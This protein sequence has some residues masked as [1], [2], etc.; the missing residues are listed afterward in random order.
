MAFASSV[1]LG[2]SLGVGPVAGNSIFVAGAPAKTDTNKVV[3]ID[4][5]TGKPVLKIPLLHVPVSSGLSLDLTVFNYQRPQFLWAASKYN[6]NYMYDGKLGLDD[7]IYPGVTVQKCHS[8]NLFFVGPEGDGH[9]FYPSTDNQNIF[10]SNDGWK[11][12]LSKTGSFAACG[13][14]M[15]AGTI[16]SPNGIVYTISS[17]VGGFSPVTEVRPIA[18]EGN[19]WVRYQYD[20]ENLNSITTSSGYSVNFQYVSIATYSNEMAR[21]QFVS[22]INTSDGKSWHFDYT[23][24]LDTD[25]P[26]SFTVGFALLTQITLP[27]GT[28]WHFHNTGVLLRSSNLAHTGVFEGITYPNGASQNF[29]YS[30]TD[31]FN[32]GPYVVTTE[33]DTNLPI[34]ADITYGY[35]GDSTPTLT[36]VTTPSVKTVYTVINDHPNND[37]AWDAGLLSEIQIYEPQ[38]QKLYKD[39]KFSWQPRQ[40]SNETGGS[41]PELTQQVIN[42]DG[43]TYTL[44]NTQ[45]DPSGYVTHTNEFSSAGLIQ[46]T[47]TYYEDP[48]SWIFKPQTIKTLDADGNTEDEINNTYNRLGELTSMTHNGEVTTYSYDNQ[49]N[50]ATKT[51]ALGHITTYGDYFAGQPQSVTDA[52]GNVSHVVMSNNGTMTSKTDALGHTTRYQYDLMGRLVVETPPIGTP[53]TIKWNQPEL[54][55]E[56]ITKG[57]YTKTIHNNGFN[58]PIET[59]EQDVS[60]QRNRIIYDAYDV[61]GNLNFQS[62]FYDQV[63]LTKMGKIFS[64]DPLGRLISTSYNFTTVN[65]YT[66]S[67]VY[68]PGNSVSLTEPLGNKT[69]YVYRAYSDPDNKQLMS[70]QEGNNVTTT[71]QR[72]GVGQVT[73]IQK[74]NFTRHYAYNANHYLV[75]ET[76]PET[77]TTVYGR[78]ILGNV[79]SEKIGEGGVITYAY[80]DNN[81]LT[82]VTYPEAQGTLTKTYDAEGRVSAVENG[83]ATWS[84]GYDANDNQTSAKAHVGGNDYAFAYAYDGLNHLSSMS[85]P[86]QETLNYQPDAFGEPT[87]ILPM[88]VLSSAFKVAKIQYYPNGN[89]RGYT[90]P[91][92]TVSYGQNEI[93]I[94]NNISINP[95]NLQ[96][97]YEYDAENNLTQLTKVQGGTTAS[98]RFTYNSIKE[99]TSAS[100]TLL[101]G[102]TMSYDDIGNLTQKTEGS[103]Q[104]AYQYDAQNRLAA[105]SGTNPQS[106][107][108]DAQGNMINFNGYTLTYN[109]ANQ[110]VSV[111][112]RDRTDS[113]AYDG[114]GNRLVLTQDGKTTYNF[115]QG[116]ILLYSSDPN[117]PS[118]NSVYFY[119]RNQ[120]VGKVDNDDTGQKVTQ[121]YTDLLG[122]PIFLIS[123]SEGQWNQDYLPY[124]KEFTKP[125]QQPNLHMS[126][127]GKLNDTALGLSY[128]N[129]RFYAPELGRFLS[130]DP[131][132]VEPQ[133][134][135]SF[136]RY[137]YANDNPLAYID[138][139][140]MFSWKNFASGA[141]SMLQQFGIGFSFG[142]SGGALSFMTAG[143]PIYNMP[144][145]YGGMTAGAITTGLIGVSEFGAGARAVE[146][147]GA[148]AENAVDKVFWSSGGNPQVE[149]AAQNF[150]RENGLRTLEMTQEGQVLSR[151]TTGMPWEQAKPL[152]ESASANFARGTTGTAHVFQN[153][154]GI[155]VQSIWGSIEYPI[156]RDN[157]INIVHYV[158]GE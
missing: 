1:F 148:V 113:Y 53:T 26:S 33:H 27:D 35:G 121:I 19:A 131:A 144:L 15:Y 67:Y 96:L 94:P 11:G 125:S 129:A 31:A 45:F 89:L 24:R 134:P 95:E 49:G 82:T 18:G 103:S 25:N 132:S 46:I 127:T 149:H 72:N 86:N 112:G 122:S 138:P 73:S 28:N 137:A 98:V 150:A 146:G 16:S 55:D 151:T 52:M 133:N 109:T 5:Y 105:V 13:Y 47:R 108:Y 85:Y 36:T 56:V 107:R 91:N 116:N 135:F 83:N 79:L 115:Y 156:L 6:S 80:D 64:F 157:N 7:R 4:L 119:L 130:I 77:G 143:V 76:N 51:D 126:Y 93:N 136:N 32:Q 117:N 30:F 124:G 71:I 20:G 38:G 50:I 88:S 39:T 99:L 111:A 97:N 147:I 128:Y 84:Y 118:S 34:N 69:T 29:D 8:N 158:I 139:T 101:G 41:Q 21:Q 9:I 57:N 14:G 12:N 48:I 22:D 62:F 58:Q 2:S 70:I 106:V 104:L 63:P 3:S 59:I 23:T 17:G 42:Q 140:G 65:N 74:G 78:D 120:L 54:G 154:G 152:W 81:R 114:N 43:A 66:T 37:M 123:R 145:Y 102:A 44:Q 92:S 141:L 10:Y 60:A 142:A 75:A 100:G 153:A 40:F 61:S 87:E 155:G 90:D 110:L 68:G